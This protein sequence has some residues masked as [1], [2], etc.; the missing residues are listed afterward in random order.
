MQTFRISMQYLL[1]DAVPSSSLVEE[2]DS[3][4]NMYVFEGQ[5]Y[6]AVAPSALD[7][8]ALQLLIQGR[9]QKCSANVVSQSSL[10]LK[11]SLPRPLHPPPPFF[12]Y[13]LKS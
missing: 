13:F 7:D 1:Q 11:N 12:S 9:N 10:V 4:E 8:E 3:S 6:S 2:S 5:D